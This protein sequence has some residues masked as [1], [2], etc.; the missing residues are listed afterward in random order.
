MPKSFARVTRILLMIL[1]SGPCLLAQSELAW[2][3]WEVEADTLYNRQD[4]SG[5]IKLYTKVIETTRLNSQETYGSL[6]KR[7][8]CYLNLGEFEKSLTDADRLLTLLPGNYQGH[9]LKAFIYREQSDT[10]K[11]LEQLQIL[12]SVQPL[13]PDLLRWRGSL[14]LEKEEFREAKR[15]L[16]LARSFESDPQTETQ[17]AFV[18]FNLDQSDSAFVSV[19]RAIEL[20]V[21][22]FPAYL[23][24]GTFALQAERYELALEYL[25]LALRVDDTSSTALFYKGVALIEL[26]KTDE[27]CK[28]LNRA[29]YAGEDDAA[30][31]LEQY[32]FGSEDD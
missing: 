7:A 20:D 2:K 9:F 24:G 18:Y 22:Y 29:F 5:A 8:V 26:K 14:Y 3:S 23:Y 12:L 25:S 27:G 30:D 1:L 21:T 4:F 32:C 11:Q 15:D 6:Y 16:E 19:N 13:N 31:Y 10:E 17:L 28:C